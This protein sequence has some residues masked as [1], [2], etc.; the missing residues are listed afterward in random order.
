VLI[1]EWGENY[2]DKF[3]TFD[4]SPFAAASIG[5]VHLGELKNTKEKVAIKIQYPGVAKSI[6][7]DIDNLMSILN[8][9]QLLPKGMYVE[10][11]I[12][13]MKRELTDECDYIR[14]ANSNRRFAELLKDDPIFQIPKVYMD[15]T[16]PNILVCELIDG[17][18]FDKCFNLSQEERNHIG[19][20]MLRLCLNELFV[21]N[22]MQT[23]PNW[24]NFFYD[25]AT[26]K[27]WLIDFGATREFSKMFVDKYIRIIRAAADGDRESILKWSRDLKFLTG[28]ET[29]AMENAHTDA[30]LI[31]GEAF[32]TDGEFD[33]GKQNT[34]KRI[35]NLVPVMLKHRLTPPPEETYSLHR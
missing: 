7:S 32:A 31:L 26:K 34:T 9:A 33:F 22:C 24:S 18:T 13:V 17:A 35:N 27:I 15:L 8:V 11:V 6:Q 3:E 19:Y 1:K 10:N 14:E 5:Q 2:L 12:N 29:K 23:D 20:H 21:F 16:T 4:K 30:V 25:A 28:Y